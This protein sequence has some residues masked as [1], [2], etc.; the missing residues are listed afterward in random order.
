MIFLQT[1]YTCNLQQQQNK[2][3]HF[4]KILHGNTRTIDGTAFFDR[5]VSCASKIFIKS[6]LKVHCLD[7]F[8]RFVICQFDIWLTVVAALFCKT[9]KLEKG[10]GKIGGGERGK[11]ERESI[12]I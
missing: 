11:M 8:N 6:T 7:F 1:F 2:L 3:V 5:A 10:K 9:T 4:E 12:D